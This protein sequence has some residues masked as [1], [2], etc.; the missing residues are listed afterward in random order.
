MNR[1]QFSN[2]L[3]DARWS[4]G[5]IFGLLVLVVIVGGASF[6]AINLASQPGRIV[7]KT[8]DADNV[9]TNYEWFKQQYQDIATAQIQAADAAA[10]AVTFKNEAGPRA[11]W[12]FRTA[13]EYNRLNAIAL[14]LNNQVTK[15]KRDYN[16][17][18]SMA[19]RDL[20]RSNELPERIE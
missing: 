6:W 7:S 4:L 18:A 8:F 2:D 15:L 12:D 10:A 13:D 11:S 14:G 3:R 20:F 1:D 17:R 9:I 16:A 19:N 5:K